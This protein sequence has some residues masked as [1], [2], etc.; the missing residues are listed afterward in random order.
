M[1][2]RWQLRLRDETLE[3]AERLNKLN[4]FMATQTFYEL[5]REEKDL[6]YERCRLMNSYVQVLGKLCE[7]YG[8]KLR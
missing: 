5:P 8:I 4:A 3:L 6:L 1:I 7:I 2:P